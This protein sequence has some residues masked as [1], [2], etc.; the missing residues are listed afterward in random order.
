MK[1]I[2][3]FCLVTVCLSSTALLQAQNLTAKTATPPESTIPA[4]GGKP[5]VAPDL[6]PASIITPKAMTMDVNQ[7]TPSPVNMDD[8]K[9]TP[10]KENITLKT[11]DADAPTNQLTAEQINTLNGKATLPKQ[12]AIAPGTPGTDNA[13]PLPLA[14]PVLVKEQ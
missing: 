1:I 6:Q 13:K 2:K 3:S 10:E 7:K 14:K 12:S 5:A 9:K 4:P 8:N 11:V